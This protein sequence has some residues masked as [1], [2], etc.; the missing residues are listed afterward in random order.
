V[1]YSKGWTWTLPFQYDGEYGEEADVSK[2]NVFAKPKLRT[3]Y[4]AALGS[5]VQLQMVTQ[6]PPTYNL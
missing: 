5:H 4:D 1:A 2:G 6:T 3:R